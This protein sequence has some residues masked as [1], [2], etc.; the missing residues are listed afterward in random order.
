[1]RLLVSGSTASVARMTSH[2]EHL[3]VLLTPF[4]RNSV[5]AVIGTGL[6][7]AIDNGAFSGFNAT[8]FVRLCMRAEGSP[9]LLWVACPDIVGDATQTATEFE[10]WAPSLHRLRLPVALVAQDG[11]EDLVQPWDQFCCLFIGGTTEWKLSH[12]AWDLCREAKRRDKLVHM[13]RV[14]SLRRMKIAQ[15]Y[16]CDSIDGSSASKYGDKY[17]HKYCRWIKHRIVGQP[18]LQQEAAP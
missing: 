16:G 10:R 12:A 6:P 17:I 5:D 9:R 11:A 18:L 1:M 2:R 8:A 13:G 14:N 15:L 7:W 4:N 3:G